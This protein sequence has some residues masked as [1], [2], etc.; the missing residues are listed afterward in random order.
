MRAR[1]L[2][3]PRLAGLAPVPTEGTPGPTNPLRMNPPSW[4]R[5]WL[6]AV[7]YKPRATPSRNFTT[8]TLQMEK[9]AQRGR[10]N[11]GP[12]LTAQVRAV[13]PGETEAPAGQGPG[14]LQRRGP[15]G[16]AS[17]RYPGRHPPMPSPQTFKSILLL[18]SYKPFPGCPMQLTKM[19][20]PTGR[21]LHLPGWSSSLFLRLSGLP[22]AHASVSK[23]SEAPSCAS[24][25]PLRV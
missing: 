21:R 4:C 11:S 15:R 7:F 1:P 14:F 22:H 25:W 23:Y 20:V 18:A 5:H 9:Q 17:Q 8:S 2:P 24:Q 13:L 16:P 3:K 6:A 10:W 19:T 12:G